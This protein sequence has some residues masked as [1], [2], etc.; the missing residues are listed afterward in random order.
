MV[1]HLIE[2]EMPGVADLRTAGFRQAARPAHE[3]PALHAPPPNAF[4][5]GDAR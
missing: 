2:R 3:A 4:T 5:S 1:R